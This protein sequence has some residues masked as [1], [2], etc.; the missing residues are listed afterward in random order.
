MVTIFDIFRFSQKENRLTAQLARSLELYDRTVLLRIFLN[1]VDLQS[2][3]DDD[4]DRIRFEL[5]EKE[6]DSIP[7]A[8]AYVDSRRI[9]FIESKLWTDISEDQILSHV[10]S[11]RRRSPSSA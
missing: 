1:R 8:T 2:L 9:F 11:G 3:K 10:E 7:D 4:L 6:T 5:Q